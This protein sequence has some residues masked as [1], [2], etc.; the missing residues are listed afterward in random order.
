[1][2]KYL[3][4]VT[5]QQPDTDIHGLP[6]WQDF[7]V[8]VA[9]RHDVRELTGFSKKRILHLNEAVYPGNEADNDC[10]HSV[11]RREDLCAAVQA[12]CSPEI[13]ASF[14]AYYEQ[15]V[16]KLDLIPFDE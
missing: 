7:L 8:K 13:K 12:I 14:E 4:T 2:R 16:V 11:S 6:L 3:A 1:M 9:N 5:Q 10:A 15:V